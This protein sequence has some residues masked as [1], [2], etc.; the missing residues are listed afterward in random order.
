MLILKKIQKCQQDD[1]KSFTET[2]QKHVDCNFGYKVFCCCDD[3]YSKQMQIYGGEN[4]A[5]KFVEKVIEEE[6]RCYRVK[7]RYFD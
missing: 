6:R 3:K 5:H 2:Y 4:S 1:G 7:K